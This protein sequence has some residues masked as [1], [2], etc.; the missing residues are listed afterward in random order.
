MRD[1]LD[2][3]IRSDESWLLVGE[4]GSSSCTGGGMINLMD[5]FGPL[6]GCHVMLPLRRRRDA[7]VIS[8]HLDA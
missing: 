3:V 8:T 7:S 1:M 5:P 4:T 2:N 6:Y